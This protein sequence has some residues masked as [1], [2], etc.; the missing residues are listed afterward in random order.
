VRSSLVFDTRKPYCG[1]SLPLVLNSI[2]ICWIFL[3]WNT[4]G[5]DCQREVTSL[6]CIYFIR[7]VQRA[8]H[9]TKYWH[10]CVSASKKEKSQWQE[11]FTQFYLISHLSIS[12]SMQ[13]L[14]KQAFC[15]V[16]NCSS[17]HRVPLINSDPCRKDGTVDR[18]SVAQSVQR[19]SCGLDDRGS[20]PGRGREFF[21]TQPTIQWVSDLLPRPGREADH[22]PSSAEVTN[23]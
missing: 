22:S 2:E 19:L 10:I 4:R 7:F 17:R 6:S 16:I 21:S 1:F 11:E 14:I 5:T 18:I 3:R 12:T 15:P 8:C 23:T 9:Y 13:Q 20:I